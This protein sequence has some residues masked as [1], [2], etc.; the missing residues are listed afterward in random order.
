MLMRYKSIK[1]HREKGANQYFA[2]RGQKRLKRCLQQ[3]EI[4]QLSKS[5]TPQTA[6]RSLHGDYRIN[7]TATILCSV[8]LAAIIHART[9]AHTHVQM[10]TNC[11]TPQSKRN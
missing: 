7:T 6:Y 5:T 3:T 9:H 10:N 8:K 2:S 1:H 11:Y 4:N